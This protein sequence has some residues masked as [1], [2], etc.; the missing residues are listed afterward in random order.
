MKL[1]ILGCAG[2]EGIDYRA[3]SFLVNDSLLIDAG[4][5]VNSITLDEQNH[6]RFAL[7]AHAYLVHI[8]D[9]GFIADN[10]FETRTHT[11]RGDFHGICYRSAQVALF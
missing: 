7:V 5:V 2:S 1:E 8:K 6:I 11:L 9:L 4:S 10:T 3:T